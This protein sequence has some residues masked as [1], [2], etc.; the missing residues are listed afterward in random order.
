MDDNTVLN[1]VSNNTVNR[2]ITAWKRP[3][4][5]EKFDDLYNRD[6]RFFSVLIKGALS[7][8]NSHIKMYD[9]SINHFI[10][11][12]GSSY[13]FVESNGYEFSWNE[14]SGEDS[15]YMQL[16]RCIVE[17][18]SINVPQEEL[19]QSFA[20]GNYERR[21]AD[22]I[23]GYNAEIKRIPIEMSL[24]LHYA[25]SNFNEAI[26][27]LQELFD[28]LI[29][30]KYFNIAYLGQIIR[31]SIEFPNSTQLE[32]GKID[33]SAAEIVQRN[34]NLD[35]TICTNYPLIN[36]K[37][38]ISSDKIIKKFSGFMTNQNHRNQYIEILIDGIK[39][40]QNDVYMDLRKY[41]FNKDG[42]ITDDEI[43]LIRD[44][45]SRFDI[46][47][48]GEVTSHDI[49]IIVEEFI[50]NT[51]NINYDILNKGEFDIANL[52]AIQQ[53]FSILDYNHDG[54]INDFEIEN[55]IKIIDK[56]NKFDINGDLIIDYQ[57]LNNIL[58]YIEEHLN[59]TY[60]SVYN[61]LIQYL[62]EHIKDKS[63]E[64]YDYII[65]VVNE[66]IYDVKIALEYWLNEHKDIYVSNLTIKELY[67][68]TDDIINFK[69][70]DIN[71]DDII[72]KNDAQYITDEI[73]ANTEHVI[74]YYKTSEII[75]HGTNSNFTDDTISD[76]VTFNN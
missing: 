10:F 64:L 52:N 68:L 40:K 17:L 49:S 14:T 62:D 46:D 38:E 63:S 53:L 11:N 37:S 30:Q 54:I 35:V 76:T 42:I 23:K 19:S 21:D 16:P 71:G 69:I 4:N 61:N 57:D 72:D 25:F 43:Q 26:V 47:E 3:W 13:M 59:E 31:C 73:S 65:N 51:Y 2:K 20:R 75:I 36:E 50:N 24:S 58:L 33:F 18:G 28:E 12:T 55:I 8:L 1:N 74:T 44:F 15:M 5:I 27:V 41:D 22:I 7:F 67:K 60:S 48:D 34:I 32:L 45:I 66:N 29:F 39:S 6:D 9:K 70:Y 56:F